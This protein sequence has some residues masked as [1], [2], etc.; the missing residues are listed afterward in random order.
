MKAVA[1]ILEMVSTDKPRFF[2]R[3]VQNVRDYEIY[4]DDGRG[5][6]FHC[7]RVWLLVTLTLTCEKITMMTKVK[8]GNQKE[9]VVNKGGYIL[10]MPNRKKT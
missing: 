5:H 7:G 2:F 8:A 4:D 9:T 10:S 1:I 6:G 3:S